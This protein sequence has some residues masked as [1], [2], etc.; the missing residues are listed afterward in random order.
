MKRETPVAPRIVQGGPPV[1]GL[2]QAKDRDH[3]PVIPR[4]TAAAEYPEEEEPRGRPLQS[5]FPKKHLNAKADYERALRVV[6][7]KLGESDAVRRSLR[8]TPKPRSLMSEWNA[9]SVLEVKTMLTQKKM[10]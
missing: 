8:K 7:D 3:T 9:A 10:L 4:W 2:E 1:S 6:A 5:R